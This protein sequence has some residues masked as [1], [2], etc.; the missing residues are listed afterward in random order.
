MTNDKGNRVS[1]HANAVCELTFTKTADFVETTPELGG[2]LTLKSTF[3]TDL[4]GFLKILI[5]A[6]TN[7]GKLPELL[8]SL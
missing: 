7:I 6:F 3:V 5:K 8:G 4:I 2:E 1:D